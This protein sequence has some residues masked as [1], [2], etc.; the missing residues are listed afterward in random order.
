MLSYPDPWGGAVPPGS[1]EVE[2]ADSVPWAL[3]DCLG[4][5]SGQECPGLHED[6]EVEGKQGNEWWPRCTA[7]SAQGPGCRVR[8]SEA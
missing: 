6:V 5:P 7:I 4:T 3:R 2:M 8:R 1:F